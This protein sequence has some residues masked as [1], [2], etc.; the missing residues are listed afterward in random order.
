MDQEKDFQKNLG[1][2]KKEQSCKTYTSQFQN[3]VYRGSNQE[4]IVLVKG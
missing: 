2:K 1:I 4:C 3:L